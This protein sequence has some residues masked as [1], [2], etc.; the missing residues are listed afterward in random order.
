[1]PPSA[2]DNR[3]IPLCPERSPG[4][5]D[6][7]LRRE[8]SILVRGNVGAVRDLLHRYNRAMPCPVAPHSRMIL[9]GLLLPLT[10]AIGG[11]AQTGDQRL[12][13]AVSR[14]MANH[15][16]AA[17]VVDVPSG[18][19]L[20]IYDPRLA[21]LRAVHPGSSLKSFTLL[22][23]LQKHKVDAHT[24]LLCRRPLTVGGHRLDC[25]HPATDQPL[26]PATALA[27]SC[28]S[29]FTN[30]ATRLTPVE[31]RDSLVQAGFASVTGW[32][33]HEASG[34]V[35]LAQDENELQLQAIG[36]WGINVTPLEL[37]RAYRELALLSSNGDPHLAPLFEGLEQSVGYG[38]GHLAQPASRL[39]VAGKTGTAPAD[40]GPWTHGWF[41]GY[42]PAG[43]PEIAL[44]VYL[45]RGHGPT[46][47]A[48][49]ARQIFAAF[50]AEKMELAPR[51]A[52][53]ARP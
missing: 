17:V 44:V 53:G 8:F 33:P 36:E 29:Y 41:A 7:L 48:A 32:A 28:N 43:K 26:E 5:A 6:V 2:P 46:D 25:P 45:E 23:L 51:A 16:G 52:A 47:A 24:A 40:E 20:A 22:T 42:A 15:R 30:A 1:M 31:L 50:A 34:R 19:M 12:Q 10:L 38:M 9:A 13:N 27:Y 3:G 14:A 18:R 11:R 35:A 37:L 21:A 49:I 4:W 39:H